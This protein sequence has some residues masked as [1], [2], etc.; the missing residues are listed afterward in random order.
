MQAGEPV[1]YV[2]YP[3]ENTAS[4]TPQRPAP[5]TQ[6]CAITGITDFFLASREPEYAQLVQHSCG[7]TGGASGSPIV[8]RNGEV[9]AVLSG[10]N[11]INLFKGIGPG[12]TLVFE[13]APSAV[14]V[15]FGQR[16]DLLRELLEG[17][18]NDAQVPRTAAWRKQV[19][20]IYVPGQLQTA[21][22]SRF[23][24]GRYEEVAK[25]DATLPP[26]PGPTGRAYAS[27]QI[28]LPKPGA[29]RIVAVADDRS[30]IDAFL[31]PNPGA[32]FWVASDVSLDSMPR[33]DWSVDR[34]STVVLALNGTAGTAVRIRAY[35]G[36]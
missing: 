24:P 11:I 4:S 29:Y 9:V 5:T 14:G 22:E 2:G 35:R 1:G 23:S 13:R 25:I 36:W 10:G 28:R 17:R 34:T 26:T 20:E 16:V 21:V 7:A 19:G 15:N 18:A 30:D 3:S 27:W 32:L 31:F 6:L 33:L 12:G 8:D